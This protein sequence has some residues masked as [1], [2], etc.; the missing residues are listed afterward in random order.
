MD[1][2]TVEN[3]EVVYND[4]VL[5]LKGLSLSAAEGRITALLGANGAGKSTTL[6]AVSG[7]LAGED[8]EVTAGQ[9]LLA[10]EPVQR[11][12]PEKI[13]R[14]GVFQVMEGRRVFEDMTVEENLRAGGHTRPSSE[15]R[16]G[17]ERVYGYF[18][19]LAERRHQLAGYMSGGEQQMLA[20]G[21]ALMARPKLLLLDEPSLGLAPLLVEEIFEI[22]RRVNA[23]EGVTVL[24]VEQNARAALSLAEYGFIMENGRVVLDGPSR[25]LMNNPDVQEFYLGL[26]HGGEKKTYRDVKHY[27]RRK[28]WLG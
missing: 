18:P 21:R 15:I 14:K 7:L 25:D 9:V 20:I 27:R 26:S 23:E 8:G 16:P 6:K 28:R 24:L 17:M 13:V 5:V 3:L 4:V 2:L 12:T 22:I 10:G 19:R 1:L 11:L